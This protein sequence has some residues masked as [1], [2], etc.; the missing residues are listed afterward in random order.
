MRCQSVRRASEWKR[1][2]DLRW[3]RR[4]IKKLIIIYQV[5]SAASVCFIP[6]CTCAIQQSFEM[7]HEGRTPAKGGIGIKKN[8]LVSGLFEMFVLS[9]LSGWRV[10]LEDLTGR[11]VQ[12]GGMA[13]ER[14]QIPQQENPI[15]LPP[16][17]A[18]EIE[19]FLNN[20]ISV[21][22]FSP[23]FSIFRFL[24]QKFFFPGKRRKFQADFYKCAISI[25]M[26]RKFVLSLFDYV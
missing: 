13:G 23:E 21:E 25:P 20:F 16:P 15:R 3:S 17:P 26:S 4:M 14:E 10:N 22:K 18:E 1:P 2:V 24:I 19:F 12:L 8:C 6:T 9:V 11:A 5:A 7:S